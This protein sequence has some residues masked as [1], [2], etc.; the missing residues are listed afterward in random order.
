MLDPTDPVTR[1]ILDEI[2][3]TCSPEF[4]EAVRRLD[5]TRLR[6]S[7]RQ[8]GDDSPEHDSDLGRMTAPSHLERRC[9]Y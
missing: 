1:K 6:E 9:S 5:E 8:S 4:G 7:K 3:W 2:R